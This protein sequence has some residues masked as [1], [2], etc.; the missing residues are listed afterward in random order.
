VTG[1]AQLIV[2]SIAVVSGSSA[3]GYHTL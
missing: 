2:D 1:Y 3:E